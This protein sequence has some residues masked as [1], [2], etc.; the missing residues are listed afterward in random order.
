[1][2]F[3][4]NFGVKMIKELDNCKEYCMEI[5]KKFEDK[6]VKDLGLENAM[7]IFFFGVTENFYNNPTA[8][9]FEKV[10][11]TYMNILGEQT[12]EKLWGE[13]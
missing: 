1:M 3:K 4:V 12:Y 9:N 11:A 13:E 10:W 8:E 2:K 5:T 6:I 7:T